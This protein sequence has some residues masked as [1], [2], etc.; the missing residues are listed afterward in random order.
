VHVHAALLLV[1]LQGL[2]HGVESDLVSVLEAV[3][4]RFSCRGWKETPCLSSQTAARFRRLYRVLPN[5]ESDMARKPRTKKRDP[6]LDKRL[7]QQKVAALQARLG[8]V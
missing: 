1:A 6:A 2:Q 8:L 4:E 3:G 7:L 5:M